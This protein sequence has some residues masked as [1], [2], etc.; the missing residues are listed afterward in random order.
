MSFDPPG[1][2]PPP[3]QPLGGEQLQPTLEPMGVASMVVGILSLVTCCCY[4]VSGGLALIA[5]GLGIAS[6]VRINKTPQ[7][8]KGKG[9][10]IA[11]LVMGAIGIILAIV[12]LSV[13][14]GMS[15]GKFDQYFPKE[16][17]DQMEKA[18]DQQKSGKPSPDTLPVDPADRLA[19][20]DNDTDEPAMDIEDPPEAPAADE[21]AAPRE[22]PTAP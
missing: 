1:A 19:P 11:G 14:A 18:R 4:P 3:P 17:R 22:R 12:M 6:L 21:K 13:G 20:G 16:L 5:T 2:F 9:F 8:L 15:S 7:A 10:T